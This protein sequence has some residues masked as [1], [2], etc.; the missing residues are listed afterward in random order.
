MAKYYTASKSRSQ[1]RGSWAVIFRHPVRLD[2]SGKPGRRVR[3]GL[4]TKDEVEADALVEELN[5]LLRSEELWEP[6]AK[7]AI[8]SRFD[9]RIL[10]IFYDGVEPSSHDAESLRDE[11]LP[12]PSA[13]QGYRS[14]LMLGTTGAGKTTV[15][16]QLLGTDPETERFPST[17]TAKTTVADTELIFDPTPVFRAA[18]TFIGRDEVIDYLAE[19]ASEAAQAIRRDAPETEIRRRLLDHPNQRYRFSYILGRG[20][21]PTDG[22]DDDFDDDDL[23]DE[24]LLEPNELDD[25]ADVIDMEATASVVTDAVDTLRRLVADH[26]DAVRASLA[27]EDNTDADERVLEELIEE[28]LDGE[29]RS[30]EAFHSVVDS[31][32]DEI[33]K[34]F[35]LLTDGEVRRNRQGWP[36]SWTWSTEDRSELV[37]S[38]ARFSSNYAP[39][40]GTLLTP[41]VSGIRVAGPFVPTWPEASQPRVVLIDGEGLGHT[42]SSAAALSTAVSKRIEEVDAVLLVDNATQPMQAAPVA[43][44]KAVVTSGNASKLLFAFTHFDMVKGDNLPRFSDRENHVKASAENVLKAIGEDLGPF[45]ERVL[46]QRLDRGCFFLG[47]I[48]EPLDPGKKAGRRT[49]E[50]FEQLLATIDSIG[51]RPEDTETRPVY[52]RVNLVLAVREAARS[53][54][55]AWQGR[56]GIAHTPSHPKEHWTRIKALSRRFAEGFADEYDTL[57]PVGELKR[58]LDEQI[59]RMLQQPVR[60]EGPEPTDDEKQQVIDGIANLIS[61]EVTELSTRRVNIDRGQAWREAYAQAGTG[62]TFVRARIISS[63]VYDRAA[64]IPAVTPSRD[65]NQF[66]HEVADIVDRIASDL[67][68]KLL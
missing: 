26:I 16:R 19:C 66:L 38:V 61:K 37:R 10:D 45:A 7:A 63:D 65:Q 36:I 23:D 27:D 68:V 62:S 11:L 29:L 53:F 55:D 18:V 31:L 64:P 5:E 4:G 52:D 8:E 54:H 35:D 50:Q 51:E 22:D 41:L 12:L 3:R 13:D 59:Y 28:S 1:G 33:E 34:R 24:E 9:A 43:A 58:E 42:P 15:V 49:I 20:A 56:L 30:D 14:V 40:F 67:G 48:N 25:A 46:R 21:A 39:L 60:W 6:A 32:F 44:M 47:G 17:S 57:R 2:I